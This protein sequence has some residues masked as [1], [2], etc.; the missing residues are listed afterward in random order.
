MTIEQILY[1]LFRFG[2]LLHS[3]KAFD[4]LYEVPDTI[5]TSGSLRGGEIL[6]CGLIILP[7]TL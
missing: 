3:A 6:V 7:E 2:G 4:S 5:S 1:S